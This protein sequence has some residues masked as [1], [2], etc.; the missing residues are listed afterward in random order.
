M[1]S[2]R[3]RLVRELLR[4]AAALLFALPATG[5]S[6]ALEYAVVPG[7]TGNSVDLQTAAADGPALLVE[8]LSHPAWITRLAIDPPSGATRGAQVSFDVDPAVGV[9]ACGALVLRISE[10]DGSAAGTAGAA[11]VRRAIL[12]RT[13]SSAPE[14]QRDYRIEEC[15]VP[16]AGL[17]MGPDGQPR[18]HVLLGIAP[19]PW[20]G[21]TG[22]R[23]GLP[24][25]GGSVG[26][27][28]HDVTGRLVQA[29]Q[30]PELEA[31]YH[32]IPWDGCD[33]EGQPAPPG[34]YFYEI[35]SGPWCARGR[36][37]R[38]AR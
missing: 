34:I 12:L 16:S 1:D 35:T 36:M 26:L 19:N 8:L 2:I 29:I 5:I 18:G 9:G 31:G 27:R 20:C 6:S 24:A 23:F 10:C 13:S 4:L 37:L 33:A 17:D 22:I 28:I 32:Q 15:C 3:Q 25:G 11:S 38:L 30:T 14:H 7:S 21:R